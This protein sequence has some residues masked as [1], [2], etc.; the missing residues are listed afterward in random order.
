M[1]KNMVVVCTPAILLDC[2]HHS[3]IRM[4]QINLLIFDEAHHTKGNHPYARIMKDF[5][6]DEGGKTRTPRIFGMTASP[7]DAQTNVGQAARDLEGLLHSEIAT[8]ADPTTL[9]QICT[10]KTELVV[11]YKPTR[12]SASGLALRLEMLLRKN[13]AFQKRLAFAKGAL[14]DLGPWCVDRFW[15]ITFRPTS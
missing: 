4:A 1:D 3:H 14:Q 2:L 6:T 11:E 7:V 9:Q 12:L 8:V 13:S 10:S 15:Q 5:Y